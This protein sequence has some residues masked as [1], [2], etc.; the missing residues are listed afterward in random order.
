MDHP[1][2]SLMKKYSNKRSDARS[3]NINFCLSFMA[4]KNLMTAK[5]CYYSGLV[6]NDDEPQINEYNPYKR[7]LD[8]KDASK[9]YEDGNVVACCQFV[10]NIK[11]NILEHPV[12]TYNVPEKVVKRTIKKILSTSRIGNI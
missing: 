5:R 11:S 1:D 8:R 2:F 9:G 10:N 4:F 7:S 6:M 3:R 12:K